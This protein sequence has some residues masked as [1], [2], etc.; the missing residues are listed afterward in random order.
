MTNGVSGLSQQSFFLYGIIILAM[1]GVE[2]PLNMAAEIVEPQVPK[3]FLRWGPLIALLA[4][5]LYSFGIMV[6]VPPAFAGLPHAPMVALN[7]VFG[8]P[9]AIAGGIILIAANLLALI[10]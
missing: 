5:T 6:I 7:A 1:L 8:T 10:L 2:V 3:L 9:L 4:Y